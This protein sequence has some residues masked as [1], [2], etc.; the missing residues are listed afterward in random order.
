MYIKI[1]DKDIPIRIRN[2][3]NSCNVKIFF[4]DN[5]LNISKPATIS[6]KSI[7]KIIQENE[8]EIY[9]QYIKILLDKSNGIKYWNTGE[10]ILYEGKEYCI[11][12]ENCETN[13]IKIGIDREKKQF[14]ISVPSELTEEMIKLNVDKG[15]KKLFKNNTM[16][17]LQDRVP[18]WSN[19]TKIKYESVDVRD[20]TTRFGSCVPAKRALHFNSRLIMLSQDKIDA[21]IV[22]ELCHMVHKNHGNEFYNL[23]KKYIPN[24]DEI[25]EWLKVNSKLV[26][27]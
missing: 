2:Y 21:V 13:N 6:E 7:N 9:N 15:I 10:K 1:K 24:Y 27:I 4:K 11:V 16:A 3:R 18:Y 22:H 26:N 17:V 8:N 23:V 14:N 12:R 5:I 25:D 19:I 20:A